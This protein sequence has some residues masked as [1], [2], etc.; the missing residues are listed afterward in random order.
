MTPYVGR[1]TPRYRWAGLLALGLAAGLA[2]AFVAARALRAGRATADR[3]GEPPEAIDRDSYLR[4]LE[5]EVEAAGGERIAPFSGFAVSVETEPEAAL[6]TIAGVE[7]GEAPVLAGVECKPGAK[8][9]IR[10]V[11]PGFRPARASTL[12]RSDAL[13]KLTIR[14]NP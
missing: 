9:P 13:V 14:L 1:R 2:V 12:C 8:V 11:K 5:S 7:R 3:P 6:V 4:P 10:V